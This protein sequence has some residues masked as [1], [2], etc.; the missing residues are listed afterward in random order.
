MQ[1][2][3]VKDLS[4]GW[5]QRKIIVRVTRIWEYMDQPTWQKLFNLNFIIITEVP[6]NYSDTSFSYLSKKNYL[7]IITHKNDAYTWLEEFNLIICE[8]SLHYQR[9]ISEHLCFFA[10]KHT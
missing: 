7:A 3:L 5:F 10:D 9:K 1:P 4:P 8:C 2:F 6:S